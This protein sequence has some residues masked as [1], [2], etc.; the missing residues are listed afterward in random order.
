MLY[1]MWFSS[2]GH[3]W[4]YF[5]GS[6]R[7]DGRSILSSE[8]HEILFMSRDSSEKNKKGFDPIQDLLTFSSNFPVDPAISSLPFQSIHMLLAW[9]QHPRRKEQYTKLPKPSHAAPVLGPASGNSTKHRVSMQVSILKRDTHVPPYSN[10]LSCRRANYNTPS[11]THLHGMWNMDPWNPLDD[12]CPLRTQW[13]IH[14]H[15]MC[16]SVNPLAGGTPMGSL[17]TIARRARPLQQSAGRRGFRE[18]VGSTW[19]RSRTSRP[20]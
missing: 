6:P 2:A 3:L 9:Q 4:I 19:R 18:D 10:H 20:A 16:P 5:D 12:K 11:P 7:Q 14:F 17:H 13:A 1:K 8:N 15:V